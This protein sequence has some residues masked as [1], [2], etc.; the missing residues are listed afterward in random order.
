MAA[1]AYIFDEKESSLLMAK[2][3][4]PSIKSKATYPKLEMNALT[5]ATRLALSVCEALQTSTPHPENI[6][7]FTDSQI[8]LKW[9]EKS[10]DDSQLGVLVRNRIKEIRRILDA[11][12][13]HNIHVFFGHVSSKNNPA[14]AGTRG[15]S[16]CQLDDHDWWEGPKFLKDHISFW[17]IPLL[18]LTN[19]QDSPEEIETS[20]AFSTV[21]VE[22]QEDTWFPFLRYASQ[23]QN[24]L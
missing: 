16:K 11:I 20:F 7:I 9:I 3:K 23:K 14:D 18:R 24:E 22:E 19:S 1:C 2:S 13:G 15:L 17:D 12:S 6:F 4:L 21:H 5:M 10:P 8:V